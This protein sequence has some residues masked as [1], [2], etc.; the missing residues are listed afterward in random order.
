MVNRM[1]DD[2]FTILPFGETYFLYKY[3]IKKSLLYRS[4]ASTLDRY[5][6]KI[7]DFTHKDHY[8]EPIGPGEEIPFFFGSIDDL[9]SHLKNNYHYREEKK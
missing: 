8:Y 9:L 3:Q 7:Q 2:N 5:Y 6:V 4:K 1:L